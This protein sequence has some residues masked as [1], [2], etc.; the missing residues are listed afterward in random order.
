MGRRAAT[1]ALT[2][3]VLATG[4][5][6]SSTQTTATP[7][8]RSTSTTST[9]TAAP[10][11]TTTRPSQTVTSSDGI[12]TLEVPPGHPEITVATADAS[13]FDG[14]GVD[15]VAAWDLAPTGTVFESP[16]AVTIALDGFDA[17]DLLWLAVEGDE[18][19]SIAPT[20]EIHQTP[21]GPVLTTEISRIAR[22][23]LVRGPSLVAS[24][25]DLGAVGAGTE[26]TFELATTT[27]G[28]E[29]VL[30]TSLD[31][32]VAALGPVTVAASSPVG[33]MPAELT[34][35]CDDIGTAE[36]H[37]SI[38]IAGRAMDGW[39]HALGGWFGGLQT[40]LGGLPVDP[41]ASWRITAE[42]PGPTV[43][44][45]YLETILDDIDAPMTSLPERIDVAATDRLQCETLTAIGVEPSDCSE[46][47]A[48]TGVTR[49][50][51]TC[52]ATDVPCTDLVIETA[53][54]RR[55]D[56]GG[57]WQEMQIEIGDSEGF[58]TV[59]WDRFL[60]ARR[61]VGCQTLDGSDTEVPSGI[62]PVPGDGWFG[63]VDCEVADHGLDVVEA[64]G[65]T[66]GLSGADAM[67]ADLRAAYLSE[68]GCAPRGRPVTLSLWLFF[69]D[70]AGGRSAR[71][72][73][74]DEVASGLLDHLRSG[75]W[76]T[77]IQ[78]AGFA[79][80]E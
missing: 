49:L 25:P 74:T 20:I 31:I 78:Q 29:Y 1:L 17:L 18:S 46:D 75:I 43:A 70:D 41:P 56:A 73:L 76:V 19:W 33:T 80:E 61:S 24:P 69:A 63:L 15:V 68:E 12:I 50:V 10:T 28:S 67:A 4:C 60:Q 23:V 27:G 71:I 2:L 39:A 65:A 8:T 72:D 26:T 36:T 16:I 79:G 44:C 40:G 32:G 38:D 5:V 62:L 54:G 48:V 30:V 42:G 11:T 59:C 6:G 58:T 34:V 47:T 9:T 7:T 21:N 66:Y 3:A 55:P 35:H 37:L 45:V 14:R 57:P 53:S 22:A 64:I 52:G 77:E 51:G 13:I